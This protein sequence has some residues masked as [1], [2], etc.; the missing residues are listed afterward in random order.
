VAQF[1]VFENPNRTA[2]STFPYV[3]VVQSDASSNNK[4]TIVAPV[5]PRAKAPA[6]DRAV[7]PVEI[8]GEAYAVLMHG[9]AALPIP[10]RTKP[11]AQL[12]ELRE[13]LPRAIDYLF[14]G[15]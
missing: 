8:D 11:V 4:T 9:L 7:F 10:P 14:L 6:S 2:R 13:Q 5:A 12:P 15:M 1:D 3:V